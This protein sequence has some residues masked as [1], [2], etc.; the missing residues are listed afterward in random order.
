[1]Q[2][3]LGNSNRFT[4]TDTKYYNVGAKS[5]KYFVLYTGKNN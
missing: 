1:M 5:S 2:Y 3:V 4:G